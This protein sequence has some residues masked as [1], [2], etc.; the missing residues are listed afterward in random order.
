MSEF[1]GEFS[2]KVALVTGSSSGIGE[3]IARPLSAL[4]AS[5]VIKSA[6]SV[7]AGTRIAAELGKVA[8]YVQAD[9]SDKAAG[10]WLLTKAALN[11]MTRLLAKSCAPV[12]VNAVAPGLVETPWTKDW[13]A[14]HEAVKA[15]AP[16]NRSA[17]PDDCV[18]ATLGLLRSRYATGQIFVV[19]G[20]LSLTI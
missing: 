6:R 2:N 19:D 20:G 13:Q 9:I 16:L 4:G 14:Q 11:Q 18:E 10:T 17:K 12:R 7:E 15:R 3:A 1:S 8:F 5:V